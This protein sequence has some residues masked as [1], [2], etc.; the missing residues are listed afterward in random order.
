MELAKRMSRI[1]TENAFVVLAEVTKLKEQGKDIINFGV[2]EPDFDTPVNIKKA[3]IDAIE[4]NLTHYSPPAGVPDF[5][6]SVAKYIKNTRGV[7]INMDN[8]IVGPGTKPIIF[9]AISALI[10]NGDEVIYPNPGYPIYESL[11]NYVGGKAV[12][13]PLLEEKE[14][15]FDISDLKKAVSSRTKMIILNS[16]QNPTGGIL[17]ESDLKSIAKIAIDNDLWVLSD[18]I[19]SRIIYEGEFKS[20][21]SIKNMKERTILIDGFSKIYAMTGWRLGY[22]IMTEELIR[23]M[24]T[25]NTNIVTCTATFTQFAGI[26]GYEG[27]QKDTCK[28]VEEFMARRDM[29]VEGLNA[30]KG[31]SCLSPKGAFYVFPNVTKACKNLGLKNSR[32]LQQYILHEADVAVLPRTSFGSRNENEKEEY[33]RL[34]YATSRENIAEGLKRIKKVIE[35]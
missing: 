33:I 26:E 15:S 28:M 24:I 29:I 3:G 22:G 12:P 6:R 13:L 10:D 21:I 11:I 4:K 16:P 2:G 23:Q 8:V 5:R 32:E 31:F 14:F 9:Y 27:S 18:E 35:K 19:Y 34:S 30:I 17:D 20:I 7:D 1:G 25:L